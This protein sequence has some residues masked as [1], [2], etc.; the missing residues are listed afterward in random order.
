M[1]QRLFSVEFSGVAG[2]AFLIGGFSLVSRLVGLLR[3]TI[4]AS[5]FGAS[6]ILDI[7]YAAF[8]IPDFIY[9]LFVLGLL[10]AVFIPVFSEYLQKDIK[11]AWHLASAALN[12]L[13]VILGAI[14]IILFFLMPL[15]LPLI[16][17]GFSDEMKSEAVALSRIML[18][19]PF[20]LG[21]SSLFGSVAQNFKKYFSFALAPIFYNIG[22]IG[23]AVLFE[24]I[25]GIYGLA[26]GVV[27]GAMLHML[28]Q[29]LGAKSAGFSWQPI[30]D[31]Q[32][33]GVLKMARLS[34]ARFLSLAASQVNFI[35]LTAIA[36]FLAVGS[37]TIF[38]FAND[39]QFIPIGLVA[40]SYAV[41]VFPHLSDSV[42][43]GESKKFAEQFNRAAKQI[44]FF[45]FPFS[46]FLFIFRNQAAALL[47]GLGAKPNFNDIFLTGAALGVFTF[48]IFA[49]S[50]SQVLTRAFYALQNTLVP[51]FT[52]LV[53]IIA[54]ITLCFVFLRLLS[55]EGKFYQAVIFALGIKYIYGFALI[56]LPL[57]FSA[58]ALINF[59][60][61]A[62]WLKKEAKDID[63]KNLAKEA[64]KMLF[65]ALTAGIASQLILQF[66]DNIL[67]QI[68]A[69]F[70]LMSALYAL[71]L[72]I[73][74]AEE[75]VFFQKAAKLFLQKPLAWFKKE[76][77][78]QIE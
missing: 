66:S 26:V 32:H 16:I 78:E 35:I 41:A 61:L 36:S 10:S 7:Y 17:G 45:V 74:Q 60:L 72:K 43:A 69:V 52:N 5:K 20:L 47:F 18:L 75:F 27:F 51:L 33:I 59:S 8:L 31:F 1:I 3:N 56:A 14:A 23:G 39:L 24:P 73:F 9:N 50:L 38:N 42:S 19:S 25:F 21:I 6:E 48:S 12:S 28:V 68:F 4:F 67:I 62:I 2:A 49:Q 55:A 13:V 57:A 65:S 54:T 34:V 53:S 64:I 11:E 29:F 15:I 22:I 58:G 71:F 46:I 63:A 40:I 76:M 70:A 44:L 77:P 30:F 37:I